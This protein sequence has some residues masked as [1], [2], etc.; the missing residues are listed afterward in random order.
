MYKRTTDEPT[1]VGATVGPFHSV[2]S[3]AVMYLR[4]KVRHGCRET[5]IL[6]VFFCFLGL[7]S[8]P[9]SIYSMTGMQRSSGFQ[10][11]TPWAF[12]MDIRASGRAQRSQAAA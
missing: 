10:G 2:D 4:E 1:A 8:P 3:E 6:S 5:R 9:N 12:R 11:S 7:M